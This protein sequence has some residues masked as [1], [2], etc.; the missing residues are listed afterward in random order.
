MPMVAALAW[1]AAIAVVP[2]SL[3]V[4]RYGS[5]L[6]SL[7]DLLPTRAAQTDFLNQLVKFN[8]IYEVVAISSCRHIFSDLVCS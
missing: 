3:L 7:W 4:D 8:L 6:P 2:G 5:T 1:V